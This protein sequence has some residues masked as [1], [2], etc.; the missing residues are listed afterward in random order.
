MWSFFIKNNRFSYLLILALV[1]LGVYSLTQ[2]PRESSPEVQVPVGNVSTVLPGAP[3]GDIETLITNELER[4]LLGSLENV[5]E[6]TSVSSEG[7]S[8][9]T[10]EFD[11]SADIDESIADL[12]DEIDRLAAE[13]PENAEEP[14]VSEF[15]F[16][17]QPIMSIAIS[18]SLAPTELRSLA[19]D[20]EAALETVSGVSR[21]NVTGVPEREIS[22]VVQPQS[23]LL[24]NL[25]T[26][27]VVSALQQ[28][29][30]AFP[31]GRI[32]NNG[33]LYNIA[34]EGDIVD[35]AEIAS[36]PV[37]TRGGQPIY[38]RDVA[39]VTSGLAAAT[40]RSRLSVGGAPSQPSFTIDIFKQSGGDITRTAA[41]V[42]EQL[43]TLQ[44]DGGLLARAKTEILFDSGQDITDD[45][46]Q[47][48]GSG[49]QTVVLVM[50]VLIVAIGWREALIAGTAIPLSFLI[51]FIGL[52]F[53][54][55][56]INFLSLF[57]LILGIGILV[58]SGIVMVEGINRRLKDNPDID[59][60]QAAI[61]ATKEFAAPLIAGTLTTVAMFAGL[62]IVSGVT[63][64]FIASI[65]FTL[66]F[67]LFASLFVALAVLPLL[68][69]TFLRR[70]S[71]TTFEQKQTAY[72]H[73]L[74]GWYQN[75]LGAVL[76]SKT[77]QRKFMWS[78]RVLLVTAILLPVLGLVEVIF[79]EQ[80]DV[81]YIYI[82]TAL[83]VG[84]PLATT[85]L[86]V[87][88]VEEQLYG[89]EYIASFQTTTGA[90]SQ[91]GSG[92][93]SERVAN[94]FVNLEAE[95]DISS[96]EIVSELQKT[97]PALPTADIV[98]SQP[99][100]G[101]PTGAPINVR[102]IGENLDDLTTVTAQA[103][104]VLRSIDGATNV[105]TSANEN[106]TEYVLNFKQAEAA[107]FGLTTQTV[108]SAVRTAVFGTDATSITTLT[109]DVDIVVKLELAGVPDDPALSTVASI[110]DIEA[111]QLAT[112]GGES[113]SLGSLVDIT[114][115]ESRAAIRHIDGDR[116]M[117]LSGDV[118]EGANARDVQ[119]SLLTAIDEQITVPESVTIE[120]GGGEA[121]ESSQAFVEMFLA[122]I[123]G[124][125]LMV[126]IL[127][128][129]FN[130]FRHTRYVL[131]I[132]PYSLIGILYGLALTGNTLSFPS[133][134][135]FIALS[136]IVVN[137][138]ILLIDMMNNTRINNP[139][140]SIR[141]V[142]L[143]SA[144]NRLR[145]ILLTTVTTVI[146]MIPLTYAD[147]IWA[148]LAY[149]VMF[150]L[151][152]SVIITLILIPVVYYRSPGEAKR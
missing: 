123:V 124:V 56:T 99:N 36:I 53:S 42:R 59:K 7:V 62:F 65:P 23:L 144:S 97:L 44:V 142:V 39:E 128:L 29:N 116:V 55:N 3:A 18:E 49:L 109:D 141:E 68:S 107:R 35:S 140:M 90:G 134:M 76:D 13:L 93:S 102:F 31:I 111:I 151:L 135:G 98:V 71:A 74:E 20:V 137:N 146:G 22:V 80:G 139:S 112:P 11:A 34:F 32:E 69:S 67:V 25:T 113:V 120:T 138:S 73:Q 104:N 108:S 95:R 94:I 61:I 115:R 16:V 14:N 122:L 145:P 15:D 70:R 1:G 63:G 17:D 82:E 46:L 148:P 45:L 101:P 114:V 78:I 26:Q 92:G 54:G 30:L 6:I 91:F 41:G 9:I 88:Q 131:T 64:Q 130:S 81:P 33:I 51:G 8:S 77:T 147:D 27:D 136:G 150:G 57:A 66:I 119:A 52:Y 60:K 106:T 10:V 117:S 86:T 28:A 85:D 38:I 58:D 72:A 21:V 84:T 126:A 110:S 12:K 103:A 96:T 5:N 24:Y 40:T 19:N 118:T 87:R 75:K 149:A 79:F 127:T 48:S 89:N 37:T 125:G 83:P 105:E 143:S 100:N 50:I 133:L 132:L 2:I 47:L 121:E 4:G 152:F 43:E 129:Q